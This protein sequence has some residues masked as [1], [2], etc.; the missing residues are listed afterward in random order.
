MDGFHDDESKTRKE[1]GIR[2]FSQRADGCSQTSRYS[3][4]QT[5]ETFAGDTTEYMTWA[6][7]VMFGDLDGP[8]MV[9]RGLGERGWER[10]SRGI[11]RCSS[12]RNS[13]YAIPHTELEI[14]DDSAPVPVY[15]VE[16]HSLMAP[17]KL[18]EYLEWLRND[19][20][21]ALKKAGVA[22]FRVLQ[23]VFG[24]PSGEIVTMRSLKNLAEID[25]GPV[26]N[27]AV[28]DEQARAITNKSIALISSSNTTLVRLRT[29]LSY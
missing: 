21:P 19:Y 4:F 5:F 6:P 20:C 25:G 23:P 26:L 11:A 7:V 24:A 12:A 8:S 13:Q 27:R 18:G 28:S 17:G 22:R 10:L 14:H 16:T 3:W 15:W 2:G 29:D 9:A 1:V